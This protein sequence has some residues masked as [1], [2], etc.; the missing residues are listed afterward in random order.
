MSEENFNLEENTAL[1]F[2]KLRKNM[3]PIGFINRKKRIKAY[4]ELTKIA[5][6]MITNAEMTDE[7]ALL[8]LSLM[9]R[10]CS[11]FQKAAMMT[12]LSLDSIGKNILSPIG[13]TFSLEVR[14]NLSL[15]ATHHNDD[16]TSAPQEEA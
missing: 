16:K 11:A 2:E 12:A 15:P 4:I 14:K 8:I 10:K 1:A 5:Q 6:Y 3:P 7:S 9:M 13:L